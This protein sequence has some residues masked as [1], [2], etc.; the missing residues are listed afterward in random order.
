LDLKPI[1]IWY[2]RDNVI[3]AIQWTDAWLIGVSHID[4]EHRQLVGLLSELQHVA[5]D[6]KPRISA[7][8]ALVALSAYIELH[9]GD[10][11]HLMQQINY[12]NFIT[13]QKVHQRFVDRVQNFAREFR[14]GKKDFTDE[15][16]E[17]LARWIIEHIATYDVAIANFIKTE[18]IEL[19]ASMTL[20]AKIPV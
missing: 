15:I 10:E 19:T 9:F 14:L 7:L 11:E 16:S 4:A 12:P 13:H 8:D 2:V 6:G 17:F 5:I 18:H 20:P 3:K 1:R